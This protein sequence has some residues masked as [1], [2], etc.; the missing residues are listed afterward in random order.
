M[1]DILLKLIWNNDRYRRIKGVSPLKQS[2]IVI[3]CKLLPVIYTILTKGTVYNPK[4]MLMDIKIPNETAIR[5]G[6]IKN[7]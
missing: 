5:T 7:K 2:L 1:W 6:N 3:A 4:K